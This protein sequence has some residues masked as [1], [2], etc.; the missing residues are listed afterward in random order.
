MQ[1]KYA[2]GTWINGTWPAYKTVQGNPPVQPKWMPFCR[3]RRDPNNLMPWPGCQNSLLMWAQPIFTFSPCIGAWDKSH[4]S[5]YPYPWQ[6]PALPV[7]ANPWDHWLLCGLNGS[8][9]DLQPFSMLLGRAVGTTRFQWDAN[10]F[11]GSIHQNVS[12]IV[13]PFSPT[14]VCVTSPFLFLL[15][16]GVNDVN[17]KEINCSQD[18]CVLA[19][20]WNATEGWDLAVVTA[21]PRWIPWPVE[22]PSAMTLYRQKR[23]FG[24]TAAIVTVVAVALAAS[25]T[26]SSGPDHWHSNSHCL[27]QP[28][29]FCGHSIT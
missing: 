5:S 8:Y 6:N 14:P 26:A 10:D 1:L 19:Q 12:G 7:T 20:C 18:Y 4:S 2:N 13:T 11:D 21:L 16:K 23:D 3:A 29:C 9:T 15:V 24:I 27:K 28:K 17:K 22:A 25:A